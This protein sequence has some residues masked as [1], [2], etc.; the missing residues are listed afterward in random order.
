MLE[1]LGDPSERVARVERFALMAE[2]GNAHA[3]AVEAFLWLM[4]ND[5]DENRRLHH[6]ARA[7]VAAA[8]AGDRVQ[9]GRTFAMLASEGDQDDAEALAK[10]KERAR[11]HAPRAGAGG[12]RTNGE[13]GK[14][15]Q[16]H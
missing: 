3:S 4:Q 2:A 10:D 14:A 16:G 9:F 8:R 12:R 5:P 1:A 6:L 7:S 11:A 15:G 13:Q